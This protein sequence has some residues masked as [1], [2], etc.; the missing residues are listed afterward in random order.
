MADSPHGLA[1]SNQI[2]LA[3]TPHEELQS[4][5]SAIKEYRAFIYLF[6]AADYLVLHRRSCRFSVRCSLSPHR[7][8]WFP[9]LRLRHGAH[10]VVQWR[11]G[12]MDANHHQSL[13]LLVVGNSAGLRTQFSAGNGGTRSVRR[14]DRR[15]FD[16]RCRQRGRVPARAVEEES[17]LD[18]SLLS[19]KSEQCCRGS[20][21][22]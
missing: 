12:Y 2:P 7:C 6:R 9:V 21:R 17:R 8:V 5:W 3:D 13:C 22:F 1:S 18:C 20:L 15:V 11:R 10:A 14:Y 19:S 4:L 16:P